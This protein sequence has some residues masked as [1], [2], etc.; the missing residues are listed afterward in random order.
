[1]WPAALG[2]EVTLKVIIKDLASGLY[3]KS[4]G[5]VMDVK[6]AQDFENARNAIQ[7][8]FTQHLKNVEIHYIYD[9]PRSNFTTGAADFP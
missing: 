2:S 4:R 9:N 5:W 8:G 7:Y 3:A 1:L 6:D